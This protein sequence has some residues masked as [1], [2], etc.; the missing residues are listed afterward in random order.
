M[1]KR[2][3]FFSLYQTL[4]FGLTLSVFCELARADQGALAQKCVETKLDK[5]VYKPGE[6]IPFEVAMKTAP[7]PETQALVAW[8]NTGLRS[9]RLTWSQEQKAFVGSLEVP[10]VLSANWRLI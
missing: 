2:L 10:S 5:G 9:S 3:S 7:S 8:D 4:L 1:Q 6:S